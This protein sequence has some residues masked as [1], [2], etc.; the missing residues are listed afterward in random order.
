MLQV[1]KCSYENCFC[2]SEGR[3]AEYGWP[4]TSKEDVNSTRKALI[5]VQLEKERIPELY[6]EFLMA[7]FFVDAANHWCPGMIH[8]QSAGFWV[9]YPERT[10]AVTY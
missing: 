8:R 10:I 5:H 7:L 9:K 2:Q 6:T 3:A 4:H 1:H